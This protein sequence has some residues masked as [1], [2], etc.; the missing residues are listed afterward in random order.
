VVCLITAPSI[1][2]ALPNSST[3]PSAFSGVAS[4]PASSPTAPSSTF[5][6]GVSWTGHWCR[7]IRATASA[8]VVTAL[9]GWRI[10]PW[11]ALPVAV[12]RIHAIPF[13]AASIR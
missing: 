3:R 12:R 7:P 5:I 11:P 8:S 10:D 13:S 2:A 9:S 1:L 6:V 4:V